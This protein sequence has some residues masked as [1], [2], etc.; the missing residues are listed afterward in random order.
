MSIKGIDNWVFLKEDTHQYFDLEGT[1]YMSASKF[2]GLFY[3]KFDANV[4]AG[5]TAQSEGITKEEV[6]EKWDGQT[7]NGTRIH[8][9][10]ERFNK[11]TEILPAD[12]PLR[13][14]ILNISSQYKGYYR[15]YNEQV[16]YLRDELVAGTTDVVGVCTSSPKSVIDIG[17]YKTYNKGINQKEV[18]KDGNFRNEYMLG[19][20]SHL[21]NSSYNK[22]C[23]QISL[24]AYMFQRMTKQYER[25]IGRLFGH[26]INPENPLINYQIPVAYLYYEIEAMLD[27]KRNNAIVIEQPQ[28]AKSV[29][30]NFG[31]S[32]W[33]M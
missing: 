15:L 7:K 33:E 2:I 3:K 27:Y 20:L 6:L 5:F 13:P 29:L 10:I 23:L 32:E 1:E 9:G 17:D 11:T 26:W 25:K 14:A 19:P 31:N 28:P 12:E 4:V 22:L 24:Y 30:S 8:N 16:L 21:Q 18:N